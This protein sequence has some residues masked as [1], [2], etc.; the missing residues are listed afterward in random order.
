MHDIRVEY[1]A[2]HSILRSTIFTML[3]TSHIDI[4]VSRSQ[5]F[6]GNLLINFRNVSSFNSY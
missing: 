2:W 6:H 4:I 5:P 3:V 1:H